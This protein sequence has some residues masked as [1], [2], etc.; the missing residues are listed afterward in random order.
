VPAREIAELI[1]ATERLL[2]SYITQKRPEVTEDTIV[3][4]LASVSAGSIALGFTPQV[5][6]LVLPAWLEIA[7]KVE[8]KKF[9]D[10]PNESLEALISMRDFSRKRSCTVAFGSPENAQVA[11][12]TLS[13]QTEI[14]YSALISGSTTLYGEVQRVGGA[15]PRIVLKLLN[16]EKISFEVTRSQSYLFANRLYS[17]VG[18]RGKASWELDTARIRKFE[19]EELTSFQET[20]ITSAIDALAAV[21]AQYYDQ[22]DDVQAYMDELRGRESISER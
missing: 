3:I 18:V 14:V 4:G 7:A 9:Q 12:A 13:P 1:T 22:I 16:G 5:P 19:L 10:L 2:T 11:L 20:P 8:E 15:E 17:L 21:S 6:A